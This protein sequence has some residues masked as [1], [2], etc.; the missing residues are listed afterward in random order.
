MKGYPT[1]IQGGSAAEEKGYL[2]QPG[3]PWVEAYE[4]VAKQSI[5]NQ[6]N[7]MGV[8]IYFNKRHVKWQDLI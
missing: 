2:F 6:R 4:W 3:I 7:F 1:G 8:T 5:P